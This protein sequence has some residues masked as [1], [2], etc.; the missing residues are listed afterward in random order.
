MSNDRAISLRDAARDYG[1]PVSTL[2]AEASRGRLTLYRIGKKLYTTPSDIAEMVQLC[3]VEP[4]APAFTLIRTEGNGLSEMARV[5]SARDAAN[6]TVVK[7][8]N[9]SRNTSRP[10]INR[11][12]AGHR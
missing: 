7:L 2:R 8:K 10:S 6:E 12:Q 3:R 9:T 11:K 4:K 1:F 5:S